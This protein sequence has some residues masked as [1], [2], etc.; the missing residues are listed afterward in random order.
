MT[1]K[2]IYSMISGFD[3]LLRIYMHAK[4]LNYLEREWELVDQAHLQEIM[5]TQEGHFG[6]HKNSWVFQSFP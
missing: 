2:L 4:I 5:Q 6:N 3:R 1:I